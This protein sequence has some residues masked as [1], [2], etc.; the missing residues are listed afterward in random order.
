[1]QIDIKNANT[2]ILEFEFTLNDFAKNFFVQEINNDF[3]P[4]NYAEL[5]PPIDSSTPK[6]Q[7]FDRGEQ[8]VGTSGLQTMTDETT[9]KSVSR[10]ANLWSYALPIIHIEKK[11]D[12]P[13]E[14]KYITI[15][16]DFNTI[17]SNSTTSDASSGFQNKI[18]TRL[19]NG[20]FDI[21]INKNI[22]YSD[23]NTY[24][25]LNN[26]VS[27]YSTRYIRPYSSSF[28]PISTIP[29]NSAY[30][31]FIEEHNKLSDVL[32]TP[33]NKSKILPYKYRSCF[34]LYIQLSSQTN[35]ILYYLYSLKKSLCIYSNDA[36]SDQMGK[37]QFCIP[38]D[39]YIY[40]NNYKLLLGFPDNSINLYLN[41]YQTYIGKVS[42][43]LQKNILNI[44]NQKV[45]VYL[46]KEPI[47]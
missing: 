30:N 24:S 20:L 40:N 3:Y 2:N 31:F 34:D 8:W 26:L 12:N 27:N 5:L 44:L 15:D 1:M 16:F 32:T 7:Y 11:V 37:F 19:S 13:Q 17:I 46:S 9:Q 21:A 4:F 43:G 35:Y 18:N 23:I 28:I 33:S 41:G 39:K 38:N 42:K 22:L 47:Y 25:I 14:Y 10:I 29:T 36:K 6:I 45:L